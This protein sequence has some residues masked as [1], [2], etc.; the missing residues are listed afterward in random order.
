M[1]TSPDTTRY[2]WPR[3][4]VLRSTGVVLAA[5]G[6]VWLVGMGYARWIGDGLSA[7]VHLVASAVTVVVLG[8][9]IWLVSRPPLVL[10]L[11][12][13]GYRLHHLRGGGVPNAKWREVESAQTEQTADG[14]ALVMQLADGSRSVVPLTLL[15]NRTGEAKR[16]VHERLNS[17][18][19]YRPL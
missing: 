17:A 5:V 16:E 19:G 1:T 8:V 18:Y 6:V 15:G 2:R 9:A 10:E 3:P 4:L 13:Q 7:P 14:P 12:T 11:S